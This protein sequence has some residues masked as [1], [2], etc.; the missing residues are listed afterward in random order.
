VRNLPYLHTPKYSMMLTR[1]NSNGRAPAFVTY[2]APTVSPVVI[3]EAYTQVNR[4]KFTSGHGYLPRILLLIIILH[5]TSN[6]KVLQCGSSKVTNSTS[7]RRKVR[8]C[9]SVVIVSNFPPSQPVMTVNLFLD[10]SAGS[11]K[12]ILWY[13]ILQR[14]W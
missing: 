12:S 9:G 6:T 2:C 1:Q 11:G 7:G 3:A 4:C 10:L 5:A 8:Y 14:F 13:V